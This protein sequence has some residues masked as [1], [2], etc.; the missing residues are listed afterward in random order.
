M[1]S[2]EPFPGSPAW[3]ALHGMG[4]N[5]PQGSYGMPPKALPDAQGY[6]SQTG[7]GGAQNSG[8]RTSPDLVDRLLESGGTDDNIVNG[9]YHILDESLRRVNPET[10]RE[11]GDPVTFAK[12]YM[13]LCDMT[14][15]EESGRGSYISAAD[16]SRSVFGAACIAFGTTPERSNRV[17]KYAAFAD[18]TIA[19][20][21]LMKRNNGNFSDG[22]AILSGMDAAIQGGTEKDET[23]FKAL[24]DQQPS[25]ITDKV[26]ELLR[27][28]YQVLDNNSEY[29]LRLV[30]WRDNKVVDDI[31]NGKSFGR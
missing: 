23:D 20:R 6:N 26:V 24:Y 19:L 1:T 5:P 2:K 8:R 22:L 7:S 3:R 17:F 16:V 28:K 29:V 13:L 11:E 15:K 31:K 4:T 30:Q 18:Q 21:E 14:V 12:A 27:V 25:S 10:K 9:L